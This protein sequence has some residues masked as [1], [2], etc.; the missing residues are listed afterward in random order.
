[1]A[2]T[3]DTQSIRFGQDTD[4]IDHT[5]LKNLA[6]DVA[7]QL[8]AADTARTA[9]LTRPAVFV[10]RIS[11]LALPAAASTVVPFDDLV[12]DTHGL[13]NL[14]TQP[15]RVTVSASSGAGVYMVH[16][17]PI[18]WD[19][20][21]WTRADVVVSKNSTAYMQRTLWGPQS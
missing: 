18:S 11:A 10:R 6:D 4:V 8:N 20:T 7:A 16:A 13:C 3:T 2:G 1:M 14:G 21:G 9:A 12:Y 5:T 15:T 19:K 17:V